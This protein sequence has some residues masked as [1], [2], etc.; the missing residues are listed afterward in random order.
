MLTEL[1]EGSQ[2]DIE[3]LSGLWNSER[4]MVG[5]MPRPFLDRC[6]TSRKNFAGDFRSNSPCHNLTSTDSIRQAIH[7]SPLA[8]LHDYLSEVFVVLKLRFWVLVD[9]FDVA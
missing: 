8:G 7:G 3:S 2:V 9:V 6:Q 1:I 4:G 5:F